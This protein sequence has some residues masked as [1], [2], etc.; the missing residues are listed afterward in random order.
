M[1]EEGSGKAN[2]ATHMRKNEKR[3]EIL[4][5]FNETKAIFLIKAKKIDL[6]VRILI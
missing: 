5:D 1:A 4:K 6:I 3:R 2:I